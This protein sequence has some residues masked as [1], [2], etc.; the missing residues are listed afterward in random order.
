MARVC[1][2]SNYFL[3]NDSGQLTHK[4]GS[5]GFLTALMITSFTSV[6]FEKSDYPTAKWLFVE[7]VG[8]GGGGAGALTT[9]GWGIAQGGGGGAAYCA[10]WLDVDT[11]PGLVPMQAGNGGSGGPLGNNPGI[12]GQPSSFGSY[13]I[14][15]GGF[16]AL[17]TTTQSTSG[18]GRGAE[19]S[20]L[21]TG[22]IRR[23]GSGGG[24]SIMTSGFYKFAGDGGHS[25]L[26]FG[27]GQGGINDNDFGRPGQPLSGGGGGSATA[28]NTSGSAVGGAGG[29]GYVRISIYA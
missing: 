24:H 7:A 5:I 12:N 28:Y 22:Q 9:S 4:P 14:A 19:P 29:T 20:N 3:V 15:P 16:G 6:N 21:G 2:D 10:S 11:L 17:I 1:V 27:G 26:G 25:G 23:R 18:V 8:G 13:V